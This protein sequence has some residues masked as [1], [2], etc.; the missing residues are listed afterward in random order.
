MWFMIVGSLD[1]TYVGPTFI[2]SN[3]QE[4]NPISIKLDRVLVNGSWLTQYAHSFATFEAG[5]VSDPLG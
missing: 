1:L 5:G 2:W 3:H 4:S